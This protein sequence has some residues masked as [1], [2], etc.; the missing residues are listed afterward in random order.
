M[1]LHH[2]VMWQLHEGEDKAARVAEAA[3]LLRACAAVV[4]GILRF[5]VGEAR[6]GLECTY[7][8]LL[9]SSFADRA[10]LQAYQSHPD[11]V[12]IKPFMKSVVA[13]RQCMDYEI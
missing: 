13:V 6:P 7:D 10:A 3:R 8:L 11:H 2:V 12:A 1:A 5:E 9:N 4:P